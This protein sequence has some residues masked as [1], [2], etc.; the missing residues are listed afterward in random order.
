M[1]DEMNQDEIVDEEDELDEE[2]TPKKTPQVDD[3]DEEDGDG[4][5]V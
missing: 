1:D 2:G 5:D 3:L 4:D